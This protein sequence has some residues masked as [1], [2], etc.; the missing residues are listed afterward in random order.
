M[1]TG[2]RV[3][4]LVLAALLLAVTVAGVSAAGPIQGPSSSQTPYIV[5]TGL[6]TSVSLLTVGDS[7]NNKPDGTPYRLVGLPDGLGAFDNGD[8]TFTL[9]VN[10]ELRETAGAT[11][12]HG[13]KGAFVSKWVIEKGTL[14]VLHGEDLIQNVATWNVAAGA[15]NSPA[16]G[17]AM[18]RLCS[19]DLPPLTA[20]YNPASGLGYNG[21]IFMNGEESGAEGRAFAHLMDGT[22]YE[23]PYLGKFSWEN[24]VAHPNT[25]NTT[26]VVGTDDGT[27]GQ[28]YVYV[29]A[30]TASGNPIEAAGLS[31]GALFGVKVDGYPT[32]DAA[33][34]IPSGTR[35]SLHDFGYV[36]NWT[37]AQLESASVANGVTSFQR[38][39]DGAWD[40]RSP[41]DFYFVTTASFSG[42][43]R[44]WRLRFD[45]PANPAAGGVIDMLL[46]GTEGPKM[47][48]NIG[49]NRRGQV[50]IQEDP[51]NQ[52]HIAKIW[53]YVIAS[54]SVTEVAQFD[55]DRFTPGAPGFLTQDEESSGI[56]D[57]QQIMGPGW[58]L[59]TAQAHYNIGDAELVEGGQLIALHLPP[60]TK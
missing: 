30:K 18:S 51:G 48:D 27:G 6:G 26:V 42:N 41:R 7:V 57:V 28:V 12:A 1:S 50:L 34:G 4:S 10:H 55:P 23:L 52:A 54:D 8:G 29:G 13:A 56:I 15:Y 5:P 35:F 38:P 53:R 45:D 39:E 32:E 40:P 31:G 21:R 47:M 59:L 14:R 2:K 58:F 46:D 3:V 43:S 33:N 37:G 49:L 25:G 44:L 19:A 36:A 24:S 9:L 22:S 20:F 17:V 60:G 16:K 11:R